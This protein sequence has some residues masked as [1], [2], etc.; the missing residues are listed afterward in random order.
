VAGDL[1]ARADDDHL[2]HE[3]F[4]D[5]VAKAVRRGNRVVDRAAAN[6][7]RRRHARC[8][9]VAGLK[10]SKVLTLV[11]RLRAYAKRRFRLF[12]DNRAVR[13]FDGG[14]LRPATADEFPASNTM[15]GGFMVIKSGEMR[16]LHWNQNANEWCYYLGGR[17]QVAVFGSDKA[18]PSGT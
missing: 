10:K 9:P 6:E 8:A 2:I 4:Y 18:T 5:D 1:L 12:R 13:D 17:G 7:R 3:A 14:S 15:S 16:K 11:R